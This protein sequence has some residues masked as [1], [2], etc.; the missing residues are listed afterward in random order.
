MIWLI[1][2]L[3]TGIA[4]AQVDIFG[5]YESEYDHI[6]LANKSYNFGYNKLR[7]DLE[8]RP[9][10][11]VMVGAN[12]NFQIFLLSNFLYAL[13]KV[14]DIGLHTNRCKIALQLGVY[15]IWLCHCIAPL[16]VRLEKF[17]HHTIEFV[18]YLKI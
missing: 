7:L 6:Q 14:I 18:G 3:F 9:N 11:N 2:F 8:S 17:S 10:E 4:S 5:Y 12:I 16:L 1:I 15:R 13:A